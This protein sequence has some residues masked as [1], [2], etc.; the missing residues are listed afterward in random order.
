L[1]CIC[2]ALDGAI[3]QS[4]GV[5]E[6]ARVAGLNRTTV[7][8]AFRIKG[9][10]A[11]DTVVKVLRV[12]EYRLIVEVH[13]AVARSGSTISEKQA[14]AISRR[15]TAALRSGRT[16]PLLT[17]FAETLRAQENVAELAQKMATS[18]EHLY[19]I[20]SRHPNPRFGT[21]LSF[22]SGSGLRFAIRRLSQ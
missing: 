6:I 1:R 11:L 7:Y 19:R 9:A 2:R 8:R 12:L 14:V 16:K 5:V 10:P 21:F 4:G 17:V 22:L 3:L 20:F 18:R 13:E 15:F